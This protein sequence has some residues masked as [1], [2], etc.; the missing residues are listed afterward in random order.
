M[1]LPAIQTQLSSSGGGGGSAVALG[2][3]D[4]AGTVSLLNYMH[5]ICTGHIF[6]TQ[7][8]EIAWM[9]RELVSLNT[10][11]VELQ[12]GSHWGGNANANANSS[13]TSEQAASIMQQFACSISSTASTAGAGGSTSAGGMSGHA[14][15]GGSRTLEI[16]MNMFEV[17]D[18]EPEETRS[19]LGFSGLAGDAERHLMGGTMMQGGHGSHMGGNGIATTATSYRSYSECFSS[20]AGASA[21]PIA[22]LGSMST[23]EPNWFFIFATTLL[24]SMAMQWSGKR[25][26]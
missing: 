15:H 17:A 21:S 6:E 3:G 11:V 9:E 25:F 7:I 8:P 4:A 5:H 23:N 2:G 24:A 14:G 13:T 1:S 22:A 18:P 16:N 19:T 20:T 12:G 26:S 10:T